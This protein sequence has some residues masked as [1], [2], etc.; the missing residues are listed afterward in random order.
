MT[1]H[2]AHPNRRAFSLVETIVAAVLLSGSVMAICAISTNSFRGVQL[3]R[4]YE[5]AWD[6]LDR[7][8]TLIDYMG[9]EEFV[10]FGQMSGTFNAVGSDE[11]PHVWQVEI[12][13]QL[14]DYLYQIDIV[15]A[16]QDGGRLRKI[17][18]TTML[19]GKGVV[20]DEQTGD[21]SQPASQ[22]QP[23]SQP[24]SQARP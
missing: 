6:L 13:P 16:W 14:E 24:Q 8:L 5:L 18:L 19:D 20:E 7:Q 9:V 10:Q 23:T 1:K 11:T 12:T 4:Q 17:S 2:T 21:Q 22:S 3:N 15:V